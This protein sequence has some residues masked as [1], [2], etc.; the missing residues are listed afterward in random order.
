LNKEA[1]QAFWKKDGLELLYTNGFETHIFN[2]S[3]LEDNL[4]TRVSEPITAITWH[5]SNTAI[6]LAQKDGIISYDIHKH[7]G[8]AQS[9][10][11]DAT[12]VSNVLIDDSG[13]F[14]F[15]F[16]LVNGNFGLYKQEIQ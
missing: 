13:T 5:P 10:I 3:S 7:S 4:V 12:N 15:F 8:F 1:T 9:K 16:G 11:S 14:M 6:A 2:P